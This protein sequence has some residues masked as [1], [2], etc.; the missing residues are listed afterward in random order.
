VFFR[1]RFCQ[2][3][4]TVT[5][6]RQQDPALDD[7]S[8]WRTGIALRPSFIH[9]V[10]KWGSVPIPLNVIGSPLEMLL[11]ALPQSAVRSAAGVPIAGAA[12]VPPVPVAAVAKAAVAAATDSSVPGGVMDVWAIRAY[13]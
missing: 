9:G 10:R 5:Y 4:H 11:G 1:L 8:S 7:T 12:F 13:A 6:R 3:R 2:S